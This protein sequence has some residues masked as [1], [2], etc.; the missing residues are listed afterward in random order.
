MLTW[1]WIT[2]RFEVPSQFRGGLRQVNR[3]IVWLKCKN[4][5]QDGDDKNGNFEAE[6]QRGEKNERS[7][8]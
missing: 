4:D 8:G 5:A 3:P 1:H 6:I 7:A 2:S